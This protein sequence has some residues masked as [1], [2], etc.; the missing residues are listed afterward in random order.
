MSLL[1]ERAEKLRAEK[2]REK[3]K[4]L[5]EERKHL[6]EEQDKDVQDWEKNVLLKDYEEEIKSMWEVMQFNLRFRPKSG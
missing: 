5:A 6:K 3:R 1:L 4:V 2:D